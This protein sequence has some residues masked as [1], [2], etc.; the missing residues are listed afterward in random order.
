MLNSLHINLIILGMGAYKA[1]I[2]YAISIVNPYHQSVF[3]A[4]NIEY[5][6]AIFQDTG[7]FEIRFDFCGCLSS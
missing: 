2:H 6:S 4:G 7:V 1:D 5:D 3:I